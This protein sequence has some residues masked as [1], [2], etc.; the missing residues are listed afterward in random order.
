MSDGAMGSGWWQA[1][2]LKWYPP[3]RQAD[4]AAP[5]APSL[6]PPPSA[7]ASAAS[8]QAAGAPTRPRPAA[9]HPDP[10]GEPGQMNWDG[11]RSHTA[12]SAT[13]PSADAPT[14]LD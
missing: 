10:S 2:D 1:S 5:A 7:D 3:Q 12:I 6:P 4:P 13:S 9:R 8:A 11:Q 14:L